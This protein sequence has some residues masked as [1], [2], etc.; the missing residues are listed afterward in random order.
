MTLDEILGAARRQTG[1]S[2]FAS[3]SWREGLEILLADH[4][5]TGML[6]D[7]GRRWLTGMCTNALANRLQVDDFLRRNPQAAQAPVKRP[8]FILGMPRTGTTMLSYLMAA[9]PARRS[10]LKWEAY[11]L[12][13]PA[14]PGALTT[15]PR[16]VA[17]KARE[18]AMIKADPGQAARH[19][20][21]ADG[22]TECVHLVAQ[23]FKSLLLAV[24]ST[25]PTYHDWLL[26]C[27][28]T[29]A[30]AHRKRAL[31]VLQSTNPGLWTLK[32]PSDGLFIRTLFATFP[33]AKVIWTHR[34]PY[35][36]TAS[37]FS[38]RSHSRAR[39]NRDLDAAYMRERFPL[40][41]AL[42][43]QRPL[44]VSRE[45]P[46]DFHHLYYDEMTAD[47]LG[48]MKKIYAWLGDE[49]TPQ[50]AAGMRGW[51]D[52]NPQGRFGVHSY[53]LAQWGL[54]K[55]DLEPY[56]ADYLREHPVATGVEA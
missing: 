26:F 43:A 24:V 22:P 11:N 4:A 45:R 38:M 49:W 2:E 36:A 1:L 15:D 55:R 39:F 6:N 3:E 40:Q 17:E 47:P 19:F 21:A 28:M 16:C 18:Q 37:I 9:D 50:A 14:A 13:P 44:E 20:E 53:S 46:G 52:E 54:G 5:R 56:F 12:V 23:D 31:Q 27:D 30:F 10:L 33:D 29:E 32:M 8:V 51:L 34:D 25:T 48:Q 41:L 7:V 42:H 35:V